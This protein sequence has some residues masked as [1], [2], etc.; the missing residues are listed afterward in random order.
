MILLQANKPEIILFKSGRLVYFAYRIKGNLDGIK[1]L[2]GLQGERSKYSL[3]IGKVV[4]WSI[5]SNFLDLAKVEKREK[6]Q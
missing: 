4:Y 3:E 6:I 2:S 1:K 5:S